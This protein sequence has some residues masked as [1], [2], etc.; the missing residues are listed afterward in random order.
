M[1]RQVPDFGGMTVNERLSTADLLEPWDA[2]VNARDRER[3]IEILLQ[4]SMS[5]ADAAATVDAVLSNPSK[6]GFIRPS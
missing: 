5:E 4:V 1:S 2:A 3:A 6:Y